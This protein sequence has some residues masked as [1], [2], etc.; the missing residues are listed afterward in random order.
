MAS[1]WNRMGVDLLKVRLFKETIHRCHSILSKKNLDLL[2][3]ITSNDEMIFENVLHSFVGIG[4]I[5]IAM[6][7]LLREIG[8]EPDYMI[9]LSFGEVA[10]GYADGCITE[11]QAI[12]SA[13]YRGSVILE[14]S[15]I[16]GGMAFIGLGY[17]ELKKVMPSDL[18]DATHVDP[19]VCSVAGPKKSVDAFVDKM[20]NENKF[21]AVLKTS[22]VAFHSR[23]I[24][25][26]APTLLKQLESVI[27]EPKVRSQKWLSSSV[28]Y[29]D[30]S[31]PMAKMC[32]A[33]YFTNNFLSCVFIEETCRLCPENSIIL[34]IAPNCLLHTTM[35]N[36]FPNGIYLR[37]GDKEKPN[38]C[39]VFQEALTALSQNG[40]PVN[41]EKVKQVFNT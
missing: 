13:Y 8:I 4:A 22:N 41:W 26:L 21:T 39:E 15:T 3:I 12:L 6:I 27:L 30:W 23:Y 16:N 40:I 11:E 37:I 28:R 7:N 36:N 17:K 35:K 14:G 5:Q 25:H 10:T 38:A 20:K 9:G 33:E 29:E 19:K 18:D 34:E 32:S 24:A 31:K 1:Q 2:H